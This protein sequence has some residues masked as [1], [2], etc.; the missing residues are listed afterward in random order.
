[1]LSRCDTYFICIFEFLDHIKFCKV[2]L[3]IFKVNMKFSV[4]S[5]HFN[6]LLEVK[7]WKNEEDTAEFI[8]WY[9]NPVTWS[10]KNTTFSITCLVRNYYIYDKAPHHIRK[11]PVGTI[12]DAIQFHIIEKWYFDLRFCRTLVFKV[13]CLPGLFV[14]FKTNTNIS[15]KNFG[16][17]L[18]R[19]TFCERRSGTGL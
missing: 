19:H 15:D 10:H 17:N 11:E 18:L 2:V 9:G 7:R 6:F 4:Y 3:N 5:A 13:H 14:L 12:V 16:G 8:N 1:M